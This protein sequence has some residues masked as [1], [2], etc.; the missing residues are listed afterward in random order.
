[1]RDALFDDFMLLI[2]I[3]FEI[4]FDPP[5]PKYF[6]PLCLL[7]VNNVSNLTRG[8]FTNTLEQ[9]KKLSFKRRIVVMYMYS[10]QTYK[11]LKK[12]YTNQYL[13][14]FICCR[15]CIKMSLKIQNTEISP[16]L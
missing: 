3:Y 11:A 1:M 7:H 5:P 8:S 15:S 6:D 10:I 2:L 14:N 12:S 4:Q 16:C 9:H 13:L